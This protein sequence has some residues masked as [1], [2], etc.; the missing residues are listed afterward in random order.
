VKD[1]GPHLPYYALAGGALAYGTRIDGPLHAETHA[2]YGSAPPVADWLDVTN[3]LGERVVVVPAAG[4]FALTLT[5]DD[6]RLQDAAF[7]SLQALL[8]SRAVTDALKTVVG[9]SRPTAGN[10]PYRADPFSGR[11]S[12]PSGHTTTAFALITPWVLYYP[13]VATYGLLAVGAGTATA[14]VA[15]DRHWPTDVVAGAAIGVFTARYLARR[16][17]ESRPEAWA[18][19]QLQVTSLVGTDAIGIGLRVHLR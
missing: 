9:R 7:T 12:F 17:L 18:P 6:T 14:R 1:L 3:L 4:V 15:L 19:V 13:N 2:F 16:H 5:T 8:Y 11:T 10:G